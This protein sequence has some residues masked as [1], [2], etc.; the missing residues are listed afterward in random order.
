[1]LS[2]WLMQSILLHWDIAWRSDHCFILSSIGLFVVAKWEGSE[3]KWPWD[4]CAG[5]LNIRH[6]MHVN[7]CESTRNQM[8]VEACESS[9]TCISNR[10]M[11]TGEKTIYNLVCSFD[12]IINTTILLIY[13]WYQLVI[14]LE[15]QW[16]FCEFWLDNFL[17][18]S[19]NAALFIT[20]VG[21]SQLSK[22]LSSVLLVIPRYLMFSLCL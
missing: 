9:A 17:I 20:L 3:H 12:K 6:Q 5:T 8:F 21:F 15:G 10:W 4:P 16:P 19:D 13:F 2:Y 1:M 7:R 11:E 18:M 22:W 14:L